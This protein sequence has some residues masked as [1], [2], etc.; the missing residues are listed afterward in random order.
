MS[1]DLGLF[2]DS[3]RR[4]V[5]AQPAMLDAQAQLHK[6]RGV[7]LVADVVHRYLDIRLAQVQRNLVESNCSRRSDS[8]QLCNSA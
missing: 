6:Q 3:K 1:W 7:A 8:C 4:A 5:Q 2:G